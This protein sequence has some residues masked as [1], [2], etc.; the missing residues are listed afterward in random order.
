MVQVLLYGLFC[1]VLLCVAFVGMWRMLWV[2][3]LLQ[4]RLAYANSVT[5]TTPNTLDGIDGATVV[6][7]PLQNRGYRAHG[8]G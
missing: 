5:A 6:A 2:L 7:L 8:P 4:G 1:T 3:V